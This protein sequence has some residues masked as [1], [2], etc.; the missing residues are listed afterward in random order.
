MRVE[1]GGNEWWRG[2]VTSVLDIQFL[3]FFIKENWICAMTRY[4]AESKINVLLTRTF[5]IDSDVRQ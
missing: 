3:F 5:P 2:V 4:H 1:R